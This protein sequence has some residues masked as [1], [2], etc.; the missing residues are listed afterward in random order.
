MSNRPDFTKK[1]VINDK[2][3]MSAFQEG[4]TEGT[5][6]RDVKVVYKV[7]ASFEGTKLNERVFEDL[8][9]AIEYVEH[10]LETVGAEA[11]I[12]VMWN[13]V[14]GPPHAGEENSALTAGDPDDEIVDAEVVE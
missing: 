5:A 3:M 13:R 12:K 10:H 9:E 4:L 6:N 1:N 11:S 14:T 8:A 7:T 2:G